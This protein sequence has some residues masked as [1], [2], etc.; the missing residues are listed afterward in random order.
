MTSLLTRKH[1]VTDRMLI[2]SLFARGI[3]PAAI[4]LTAINKNVI[5]DQ[6]VIDAVYFV[7][8]ATIIFSSLRV[9]ILQKY[10]LK[11]KE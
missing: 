5:T 9:F 2:N 10:K 8:T 11:Q 1:D 3:A 6:L 7:I 4:I